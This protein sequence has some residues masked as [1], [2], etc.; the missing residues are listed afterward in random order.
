MA[1]VQCTNNSTL[2]IYIPS[3]ECILYQSCVAHY[4]LSLEKR[5]N[6]KRFAYALRQE[7]ST[8]HGSLSH[9]ESSSPLF[10]SLRQNSCEAFSRSGF[11]KKPPKRGLSAIYRLRQQRTTRLAELV[12]WTSSPRGEKC[13]IIS[14]YQVSTEEIEDIISLLY[15]DLYWSPLSGCRYWCQRQHLHC[16]LWKRKRGNPSFLEIALDYTILH[17][18]PAA[19]CRALESRGNYPCYVIRSRNTDSQVHKVFKGTSDL[20]RRY[21]Q[22]S[23]HGSHLYVDAWWS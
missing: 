4:W 5:G 13:Y 3:V 2:G 21:S 22:P 11:Y 10:L 19:A 17:E 7:E 23:K 12:Q 6:E 16:L 20:C 14:L 8:V 15:N 1:N 9:V 18:A